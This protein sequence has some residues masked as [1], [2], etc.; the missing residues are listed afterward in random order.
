MKINHLQI[1]SY[2]NNGDCLEDKRE[3]RLKIRNFDKLFVLY[4]VSQLYSIICIL[5]YLSYFVF[6]CIIWFLVNV[7]GR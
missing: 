5:Y 1:D 2:P 6:L 3:D 4:C 7:L